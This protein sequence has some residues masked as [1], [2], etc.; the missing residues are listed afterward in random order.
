MTPAPSWR[1]LFAELPALIK[2]P[3]WAGACGRVAA[4]QRGDGRPVL[5]IPGFLADDVY[6]LR[7]R[8]TLAL[9]GYRP[10]AWELGVNCGVRADLLKRLMARLDAIDPADRRVVLIGWS[11]GG[12]YARELAKLRPE[13]I[14]RVLTLGSP[15]SGNPRA[16]NAWRLYELINRHPVDAPPIDVTLAVKPP[17]PTFALW[18]ARD[19]IVAPAAARGL[20]SESDR[21]IE[22][23][24]RHMDFC[25]NPRALSVIL[26]AIGVP[27]GALAAQPVWVSTKA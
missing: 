20:P 26:D 18:S 3:F 2:R 12:L 22:V 8:R 17:V 14:D 15:F 19:G 11:L 21:R 1:R 5:V 24:C 9:A 27:L 10:H 25:S 23:D 13:R 4:A 7:L 16:N 6:T